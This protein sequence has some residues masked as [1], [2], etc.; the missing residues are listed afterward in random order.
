MKRLG[1]LRHAKS[2]WD[3]ESEDFERPISA[4]GRR[5]AAAMGTA[6]REWGIAFDTLLASPARRV[7]ETIAMVETK[8]GPLGAGEEPRIYL[9]SDRTLLDLVRAAPDDSSS[10]L[11]LGHN[12]GLHRLA[13]RLAGSGEPELC[14]RLGEK[15]PTATLAMLDLDIARWRDA[16]PGCGTLTMF[17][18]PQD[19]EGGG[20]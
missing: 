19:L 16:G 14:A 4:R 15:Y 10:L 3:G 6:M 8:Y 13:L 11:L 18:R 12:P 5:A 2:D 9:A 7:A 17:L 1:L 20:G